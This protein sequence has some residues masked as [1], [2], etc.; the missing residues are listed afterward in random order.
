MVNHMTCFMDALMPL[1]KV[2][3]WTWRYIRQE[4]ERHRPITL[5]LMPDWPA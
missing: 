2:S 1:L 5:M 3:T 4:Y